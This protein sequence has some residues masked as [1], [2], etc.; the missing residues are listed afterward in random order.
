MARARLPVNVPCHRRPIGPLPSVAC[1]PSVQPFY[2]GRKRGEVVRTRTTVLQAHT[3]QWLG[4]FGNPGNGEYRTELRRAVAAIQSYLKAHHHPEARALLRLDGQYGTGAV[5]S[6]LAGLA[7]VSRGKDSQILKRV[8]IQA[9]LKLPPDQQLS[10]PESGI[11]R[12]LYDCPDLPLGPE[13]VRCRVIVATHLAGAAKS[14]I[15]V[16]RSGVVYELFLTNLPQSA[17]TAADVVALYLH[18]GAFENALADED[19]EQDPDRWCSHSAWGQEAWHII[20]QWV[21]NLRLELGH[22]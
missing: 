8:E 9:R 11:V 4:T 7:Y 17:F 10:H 13:G 22:Q 21:W 16:T 2:T 19:V 5:L 3:Y 12:T 18:R 1:A 14:R 6:D 20:S 15:G